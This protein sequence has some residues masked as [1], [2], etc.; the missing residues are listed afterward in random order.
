MPTWN[1]L[2]ALTREAKAEERVA[3]K[4]PA[5]MRGLKPDTTLIIFFLGGRGG[6]FSFMSI[7][8]LYTNTYTYFMSIKHTSFAPIYSA[9]S[10]LKVIVESILTNGLSCVN[11]LARGEVIF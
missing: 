7:K 2:G 10:Y 5:V 8:H 9:Y 3:E 1:T 4:I 6:G 11:R